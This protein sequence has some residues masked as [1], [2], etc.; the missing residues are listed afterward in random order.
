MVD[1]PIFMIVPTED[2]DRLARVVT[3]AFVQDDRF[4]LPGRQACFVKFNG[5]SQEIAHMLD[6]AGDQ[7]KEDRPCPAVITLVTTYGG[8]APTALWEWLNTRKES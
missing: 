7:N 2:A 6:L 4:I 3:K 1:M 5:T 8:Y